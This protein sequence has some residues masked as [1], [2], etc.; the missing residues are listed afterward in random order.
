MTFIRY[1]YNTLWPSTSVTNSHDCSL[2]IFE[3]TALVE[4]V[5]CIPSVFKS[6]ISRWTQRY[7]VKLST[8]EADIYSCCQKGSR[9][10][11]FFLLL[12]AWMWLKRNRRIRTF[13]SPIFFRVTHWCLHNIA[14]SIS[15]LVYLSVS[16]PW[17]TGSEAGQRAND[18]GDFPRPWAALECGCLSV[19]DGNSR[20]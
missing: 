8:L 1:F 19:I 11:L 2:D 15:H 16:L 9:S 4:H 12:D 3:H 17:N 13:G 6:G 10:V 20:I 18:R 14:V 5:A 7:Q